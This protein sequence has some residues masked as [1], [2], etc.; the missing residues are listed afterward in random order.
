MSVQP[1]AFAP[2]RPSGLKP[3]QTRG[4]LTVD[5]QAKAGTS[6]VLAEGENKL[7]IS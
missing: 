6:G 5:K 4:P 7:T 2:F 3:F 1:S